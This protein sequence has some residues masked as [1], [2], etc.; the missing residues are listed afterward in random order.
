MRY[1]LFHNTAFCFRMQINF[2]MPRVI[3][4]H[5]CLHT[6]HSLIAQRKVGT[7]PSTRIWS[8]FAPPKQRRSKNTRWCGLWSQIILSDTTGCF[9]LFFPVWV[10]VWVKAFSPS[11]SV[12]ITKQ[13]LAI[14]ARC[15][16]CRLHRVLHFEE[17]YIG[18][19]QC[20][21][22]FLKLPQAVSIIIRIPQRTKQKAEITMWFRLFG[23]L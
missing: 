17:L 6:R 22:W 4:T 11:N 3:S 10:I 13:N 14:F 9:R 23:T 12:T 1:F 16:G 20:L 2:I 19:N 18:R 15:K 21:H 5:N 7:F 8:K